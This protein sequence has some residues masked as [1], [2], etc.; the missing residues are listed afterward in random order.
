MLQN[1]AIEYW[2]GGWVVLHVGINFARECEVDT[3]WAS[4]GFEL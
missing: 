1:N 4:T 2:V 3:M